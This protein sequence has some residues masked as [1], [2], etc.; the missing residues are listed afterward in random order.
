MLIL[1]CYFVETRA[2]NQ[3]QVFLSTLQFR[4]TPKTKNSQHASP[5]TR[6]VHER[7]VR[8][9]PLKSSVYFHLRVFIYVHLS[10]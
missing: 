3:S 6:S 4:V 10:F 7:H 1:R 9:Y 2:V 8:N 5:E